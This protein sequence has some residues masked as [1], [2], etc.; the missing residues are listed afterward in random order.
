MAR[1]VRNNKW[2]QDNQLDGYT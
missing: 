2:G 1:V